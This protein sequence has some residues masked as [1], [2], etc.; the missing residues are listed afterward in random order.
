M[1]SSLGIH[2][3]GPWLRRKMHERNLR[4]VD[5]AHGICHDMGTVR[6]WMEGR[7]APIHHWSNV[8]AFLNRYQEVDTHEIDVVCEM[9]GVAR[10]N[11]FT[12]K[13][14]STP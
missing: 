8:V 2:P 4:P 13:P 3:F 1:K 7:R 12:Q 10:G 9:L 5:L 14:R 11:F 6:A